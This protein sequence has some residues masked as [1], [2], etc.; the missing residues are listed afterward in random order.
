MVHE[1]N[2]MKKDEEDFLLLLLDVGLTTSFAF[3]F[4]WF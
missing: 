4:C 3:V 2:L 1:I